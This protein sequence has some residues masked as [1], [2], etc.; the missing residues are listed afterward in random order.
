[1]F[2]GRAL[3][4]APFI[5]VMTAASA[6]AVQRGIAD[7]LAFDASVEMGTWV[8]SRSQPGEATW[9]WVRDDLQRAVDM[10]ADPVSQELLGVLLAMRYDRPDLTGDAGK[11]FGAA[12]VARPSSGYTWANMAEVLYQQGKT[13]LAFEAA[14]RRAAEFGPSEPEVQ[15]TVANLGLAVY[16]EVSGDTRSAIDRLVGAGLRRNPPEMLQI[17]GR[18]GRLDVACRHAKGIQ[19]GAHQTWLHLCQSR[20]ATS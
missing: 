5:A 4:A 16:E 20:E 6:Y 12:L 14:L 13:G 7:D 10:M 18:R 3:V 15:R 8:A 2:I 1:M 19:S 11:H 9:N 17:S